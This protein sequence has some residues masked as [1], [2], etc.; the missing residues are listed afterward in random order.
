[1]SNGI[2]NAGLI[3]EERITLEPYPGYDI[4]PEEIDPTSILGVE[5][6]GLDE[7][8]IEGGILLHSTMI[9]EEFANVY[10]YPLDDRKVMS[11]LFK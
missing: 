8:E 9:D 4:L 6:I 2:R 1:M 11:N 5:G 10:V 3:G 7:S